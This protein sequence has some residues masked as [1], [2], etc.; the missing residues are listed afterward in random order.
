VEGGYFGAEAG[1]F[2][3]IRVAFEQAWRGFLG[4]R[5]KKCVEQ[6]ACKPV[7]IETSMRLLEHPP[8]SGDEKWNQP[9]MG[10]NSGFFETS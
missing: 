3:G 1:S 2:Q 10:P 4:S 6:S 7:Y 9:W 5:G 8:I